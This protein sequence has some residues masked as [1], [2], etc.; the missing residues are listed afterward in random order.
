MIAAAARKFALEELPGRFDAEDRMDASIRSRSPV[1]A[2]AIA[3]D[4][5]P[6]IL[7]HFGCKGGDEALA[8]V[9]RWLP[10][11][12]LYRWSGSAFVVVL[13]TIE[14]ARL[15]LSSTPEHC[16]VSMPADGKSVEIPLSV[17]SRIL[18]AGDSDSASDLARQI[19]R[20]VSTPWRDPSD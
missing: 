2:V 15:L 8:A 13:E 4:S 14:A 6:V 18:E 9:A 16:T 5:F 12:R 17:R 1:C 10:G 11:G 3:V 20:W 7:D 19:D